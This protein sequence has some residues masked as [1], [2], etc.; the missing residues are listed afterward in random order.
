[1][2]HTRSTAS[3]GVRKPPK[4][5]SAPAPVVVK[6][7]NGQSTVNS[8]LE[9]ELITGTPDIVADAHRSTALTFGVL[10]AVRG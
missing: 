9:P 7:T 1:L 4:S 2:S 3:N 6:G 10:D 8:S 5:R